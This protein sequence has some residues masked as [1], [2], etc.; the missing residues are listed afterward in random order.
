MNIFGFRPETSDGLLF[1]NSAGDPM[2]NVNY[3][4]NYETK[5]A[6]EFPATSALVIR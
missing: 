5:F 6:L 2:V 3:L 4:T 1:K